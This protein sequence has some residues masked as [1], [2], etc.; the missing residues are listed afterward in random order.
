MFVMPCVIVAFLSLCL[1]LLCFGLLVRTQSRPCGLFHHPYTLAHIKGFGSPPFACLYMTPMRPHLGVTTWDIHL[2]MLGCSMHALLFPIPCNDMLTM[3]VCATRWLSLHL[4]MLAYMSMH[5]PCLL[6]C[7]P[8]FNTMKL[9]TFNPNLH[10][11]LTDTTFY[12]LSCL[13]SLL[14]VCLLS[15]MFIC[16]MPLSYALCAFSFHCLSVGFLSLPLHVCTWSEDAW[17]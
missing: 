2:R 6:M 10:L 17:S 16:S 4:Y 11:S 15:C 9:W 14:F 12:V 5:E 8:S 13:F 1:S 7:R 3:P